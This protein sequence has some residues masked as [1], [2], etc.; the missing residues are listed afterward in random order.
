MVT[1]GWTWEMD[2]NTIGCG[3]PDAKT[4]EDADA[5]MAAWNG[6][7][8]TEALACLPAMIEANRTTVMEAEEEVRQ[9]DYPAW[10]R[11]AKRRLKEARSR[12][13]GCE[14]RLSS[15]LAA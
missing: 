4:R 5:F 6:R 11:A 7:L 2:N 14:E 12:L 13:M 10:K 9:A 15:L 8:D 3:R 1:D